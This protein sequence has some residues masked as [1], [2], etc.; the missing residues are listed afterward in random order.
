MVVDMYKAPTRS[1]PRE[2]NLF[3]YIFD[4]FISDRCVVCK[5]D[6]TLVNKKKILKGFACSYPQFEVNM[7]GLAMFQKESCQDP[8]IRCELAQ[9]QTSDISVRQVGM[10]L[11]LSKALAIVIWW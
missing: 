9:V 8:Q 7:P 5:R 2:F 4:L 1:R 10:V 3:G 6:F 11:P